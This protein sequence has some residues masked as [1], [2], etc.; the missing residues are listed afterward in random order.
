[1][2]TITSALPRAAERIATLAR[3][4]IDLDEVTERLEREGVDTFLASWTDLL[5]SVEQALTSARTE[6][7]EDGQ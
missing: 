2:D 4:G 5:T 3:I 6:S 7:Q 1:M